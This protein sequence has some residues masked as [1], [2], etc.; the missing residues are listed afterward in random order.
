MSIHQKISAFIC[1][2]GLLANITATETENL[3]LQVLPALGK[4][5]VDGNYNDWDLSGGTFACG[6]V[7]N[8]ASS[9]ALWFH[10]MY[11]KDGLYLLARWVDKTPMNNPGS[12]KGD[13]GFKGDSLQVRIVTAPDVSAPA[14]SRAGGNDNDAP[15]ARTSHLTCW[16]DK[17]GI[18]LIDIAYGRR[19]NEGGLKNA[20]TEGAQQAFQRNADGN[21][22]SQEISLP[23]KLLSKPD[24]EL[25]SGSR[26]LM[27]IEPNFTVG[28]GGRLSIK[29]IFKPGVGIDRVFTFQG[30]GSWG[31]ATLAPAGKLALRPVRLADG[32]EFPVTMDGGNLVVNWT[33]VIKN[34]LPEGFKPIKFSLPKD[35][36][37]SLN[38]FAPDGTVARQ[39]LTSHF[40]SKGE[41]EVLW[42]GLTTMSVRRPGTALACW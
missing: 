8:S 16:R 10:A 24:L 7:E 20:K 6:D 30:N 32:R 40:F 27:T 26:L 29:D 5:V 22:Y 2:L 23:W 41:H 11:D 13:Y 21:G 12:S 28:T 15:L 31:Y 9:Y 37:V 1:C 4:V 39:L 18:D 42:D 17:D 34:R 25:T 38:I 3:D 14:V 36:Y 19:F 33:G 35:G